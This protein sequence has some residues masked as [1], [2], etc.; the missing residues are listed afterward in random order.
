MSGTKGF[1]VG[2]AVGG[3]LV[4]GG[5]ML[6]G[7]AAQDTGDATFATLKA[8]QIEIVDRRGRSTYLTL[9]ASDLGGHVSLFDKTGKEVMTFGVTELPRP[10][11]G[12]E[13]QPADTAD[14]P[15]VYAGVS[16]IR[17]SDGT[18]LIRQSG[19][20]FGGVIGVR[21]RNGRDAVSAG[22]HETGNGLIVV[23]DLGGAP[24]TQILGTPQ[25]G[26]YISVD[27]R[28]NIL[29]RMPTLDTP[30]TR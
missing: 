19:T 9:R 16:D 8:Q 22:V 28:G 20:I 25:G 23:H 3:A 29:G 24:V 7:M 12:P 13:E 26:V 15:P 5:I 27:R 11:P 4:A 18:L 2:M 17:A 21:T 6:G 1:V 14:A 10:E 30:G